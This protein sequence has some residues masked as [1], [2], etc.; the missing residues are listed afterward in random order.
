MVLRMVCEIP[1]LFVLPPPSSSFN[2]GTLLGA[3]MNTAKHQIDNLC[4]HGV[5]ILRIL[6]HKT[7]TL[8]ILRVVVMSGS[9][10]L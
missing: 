2:G 4:I 7:K 8:Y 10:S 1:S 9:I 5:S 3:D 6:K